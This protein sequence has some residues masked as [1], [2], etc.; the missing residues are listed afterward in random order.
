MSEQEISKRNTKFRVFHSNSNILLYACFCQK[1]FR[2]RDKFALDD[3]E[4]QEK[5][6]QLQLT[7]GG[8]PLGD[9]AEDFGKGNEDSDYEDVLKG[10]R[11]ILTLKLLS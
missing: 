4:I 9:V 6:E 5:P 1:R 2:K 10:A 11:Y 7:H 8:R 3:D